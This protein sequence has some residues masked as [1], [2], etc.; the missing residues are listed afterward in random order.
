[1]VK[2]KEQ[3]TTLLPLRPTKEERR[4]SRVMIGWI[5]KVSQVA[6]RYNYLAP[7]NVSRACLLMEI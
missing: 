1:M 5:E 4:S 7:L 3:A 2:E 6:S